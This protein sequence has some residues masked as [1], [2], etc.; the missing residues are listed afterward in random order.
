M[1][2][3]DTKHLTFADYLLLPTIRQRYD[4]IDGEM[5]MSDAPTV[6]HQWISQNIFLALHPS[7]RAN[8]RG[9]LIYAP[10]D[11]VVRR[12]PLRTRQPDLF[13]FLRGRD[14]VGDLETFL[15]QPVLEVAPDITIEIISKNETRRAR[16]EKIEDY[17]RIG[18]K[19]CW[20]VSPQAQTVEVLR[21]SAEGMRTVGIYGMGMHVHS[22]ILD[23]LEL[24]VDEVFV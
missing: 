9:I 10:C 22:E 14:D 18:V 13:I 24:S 6:R 3:I 7:L 20:I 21:L 16:M 8:Q 17:R 1:P 11:I 4:I 23:G 5:V 15:D 2:E 12:D 19:E